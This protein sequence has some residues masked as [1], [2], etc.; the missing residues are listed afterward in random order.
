MSVTATG[1]YQ[2]STTFHSM[3]LIA[4]R[5]GNENTARKMSQSKAYSGVSNFGTETK[6]GSSEFQRGNERIT[7]DGERNTAEKMQRARSYSGVS[8]FGTETRLG[9]SHFQQ[10]NARITSD[11]EQSTAIRMQRAEEAYVH[12]SS[13]PSGML[14]M[15]DIS[16]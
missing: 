7:T 6:L 13:T 9:S 1:R 8:N 16:A 14:A 15:L 5:Q 10:N 4:S 11:G 2:P 3:N 12:S